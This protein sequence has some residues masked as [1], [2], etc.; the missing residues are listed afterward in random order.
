MAGRNFYSERWADRLLL[1]LGWGLAGTLA[2]VQE[3]VAVPTV[4]DLAGT[5]DGRAA[6]LLVQEPGPAATPAP[7]PVVPA[8]EPAAPPPAVASETFELDDVT[9]TGTFRRQKVR[10][11]PGSV[12]VI[13]QKEIEQKGAR[14]VGDALRGVPG[15]VSN[16]SGAGA[17]VHST[18]FIR[19]LPTTSTALLID[20]RSIN[21]LNQEHVDLNELP[22]AGIDRI[23]VLTGGATTLYGSTAVGGVIN[24]ITKRPPKIFEGNVEVTYGS[25]G[26]SDYRAYVGGPLGESVRFNLYATYFNTNNDFFYRVERP[27]GPVPV[28]EDKRINGAFTSTNY[29]FD[30]D[31]DITPRT[32]LNFT[33]YYR[34]GSRGISLFAIRD[35]RTSIP[36]SDEEGNVVNLSADELGLNGALFPRILI[37]YY[38]FAVTSNTRLGEA[39]DSNLQVRLSYDRGRTTEQEV[40]EGET[41]F[42]TND[43]GIFGTRV[44][45]TW[46]VAPAL[47][48]SYGFDFL[49]EGGNSFGSENPLIYEA[50]I[51][52]PSLFAL[53]SYKPAD[54][55]TV[56]L[57]LRGI[58][59][60]RATSREFNRDF[61][62]ALTPSVGVRWQV[63]PQLALRS[64][65]SRVYKTPNFND[66]FGRGEILGNP[67]LLAESGSTFDAGIDWQPSPTSLIR[68]SY[69]LNDI[70]NLQ[71][72]NLIEENSPEDQLLI[73]K[74]GYELNERVRVNFPRVRS[75]G[76]ELAASWQ[77]A[78]YW[79]VFATETYT[80]SRVDRGFKPAYTQTQY[81]LVPFHSGRAGFSYDSPGGFRGALF[82]N[83]QGLR[84]SD[85]LH[86]GPGFAELNSPAGLPI[87]NAFALPPGALLP[88]YTTLDF[89]FRVPV[90]ENLSVLGYLDN[91][92]N[93]R[94]ER[95][96]GNGAPPINFRLGLK[97]AF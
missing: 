83:F 62:G 26:Y 3:A 79:T 61:N 63:I 59:G 43:I 87:A 16:L 73:D 18:Y 90:T 96:Y 89:S 64:T 4:R 12:Y 46:Q 91:L 93:T 88:G 80:D 47:N 5:G 97:A 66:L 38:G 60:T 13:D 65:F 85:P 95:N 7:E 76:F 67:D 69:F 1:A 19:G 57:G 20:G 82:V 42:A 6:D 34:Q 56:T 51:S 28:F 54:D 86:I 25:Y 31:W 17:D 44:L 9:V 33:S 21:N 81:P 55:V 15:V 36:A 39:D 41:E 48:L 52:Q 32:T 45:H 50:A 23:E 14:T 58:F 77:F 71:G 37:D 84:S 2:V 29:G 40:E 53:A 27:G 70:D 75:S 49:R 22:V 72:Y 35:P 30:L 11:I 94:Y 92:T 8:V 78:P 68:F 24:V 74:F 10:E